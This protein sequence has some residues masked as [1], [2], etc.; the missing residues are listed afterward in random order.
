MARV[1]IPA[2]LRTETQGREWVEAEGLTVRAVVRSLVSAYPGLEGRL[3]R[4]GGSL[5]PG[6]AVAIDGEISSIGL[7]EAVEADTEIQFLTAI[8]GG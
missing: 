4:E 8:Q 1:H 5:V 7:A 3:V 2:L 6:L